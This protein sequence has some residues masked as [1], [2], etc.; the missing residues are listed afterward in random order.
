MRRA[1]ETS[2]LVVAAAVDAAGVDLVPRGGHRE[3]LRLVEHELRRQKR[4]ADFRESVL[5]VAT[6]LVRCADW[7]TRTTRPTR[8]R[9]AALGGVVRHERT[10]TRVV[11]WLREAGLLVTVAE[12][13]RGDFAPG[14]VHSTS[15]PSE[16]RAVVPDGQPEND[17]AVYA[18]T[19]PRSVIDVTVSPPPGSSYVGES[20]PSRAREGDQIEPL[21]GRPVGAASPH[22]DRLRWEQLR[23]HPMW[24]LS[25]TPRRKGQRLVAAERMRHDVL[26][27]RRMSAR[28]IASVARP[29]WQANWTTADV[30]HAIDH[31]VTTNGRWPY[32][33]A[34]HVV[35]MRDWLAARL[36]DWLD[37][38]G[39]PVLSHSQRSII[40]SRAARERRRQEAERAAAIRAAEQR[41]GGRS[42]AA[43]V[44]RWLGDVLTGRDVREFDVEREL[45]HVEP[46]H[47]DYPARIDTAP[48]DGADVAPH[49]ARAW[50]LDRTR[51]DY[52]GSLAEYAREHAGA[53]AGDVARWASDAARTVPLRTWLRQGF[54]PTTL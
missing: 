12:G 5:A 43:A 44:R 36:A 10:V 53:S 14:G 23:Q 9:M 51:H 15:R 4:R 37:A 41:R 48:D 24:S 30:I 45:T 18:L 29:F 16:C 26:S 42:T 13:R 32:D 8:A 27:L 35:R 1:R 52:S 20:H 34:E 6:V 40:E 21:R 2:P 49:I 38:D 17:A 31:R 3:Y 19:R 47:V 25:A 46:T 7:T 22:A 39:R 28:A 11:R 33:A 50:L 54:P